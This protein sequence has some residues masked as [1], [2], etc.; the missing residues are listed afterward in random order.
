M[1]N[2]VVIDDE[3]YCRDTVTHLLK[4]YFPDIKVVAESDSVAKGLI[5]I[6]QNKPDLL[7][8]DIELIDGT[9]FDLLSQ[10]PEH[11]FQLVFI[12]AFDHFAIQAIK[13]SA[14]DYLLKPLDPVLFV[15]AIEKARKQNQNKELLKNQINVINENSKGFQRIAL[16]TRDGFRFIKLE[17]VLYCKSENN[18]TWFYLRNSEKILVTKTLKEYAE[19]LSEEK[20]VRI[21]Q[22]YLI[23]IDFVE[24]YIKGEG[25]SVIMSDGKEITVSRRKKDLFLNKI[26][27]RF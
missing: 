6:L 15:K 13:H 20:F 19:V 24:E 2:A 17:N 23:N 9:G 10:L 18:Y 4:E 11:D 8:L 25:G 12:T 1:L 7:L 3:M 14:I 26:K 16:P 22:S 27:G 21:H 5:A